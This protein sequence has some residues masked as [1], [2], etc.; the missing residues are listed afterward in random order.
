MWKYGIYLQGT[1]ILTRMRKCPPHLPHTRLALVFI[2]Y[3]GGSFAKIVVANILR[4]KV[5]VQRIGFQ[6]NVLWPLTRNHS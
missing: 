3:M 6:W 2:V 5:F 1:G 4:V